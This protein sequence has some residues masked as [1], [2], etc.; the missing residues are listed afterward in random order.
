MTWGA[1]WTWES[2][3]PSRMRAR[4]P[5]RAV[6]TTRLQIACAL[7][8]KPKLACSVCSQRSRAS[9]EAMPHGKYDPQRL[10]LVESLMLTG[11]SKESIVENVMQHYKIRRCVVLRYYERVKRIWAERQELPRDEKLADAWQVAN[12]QFM[13]AKNEGKSNLAHKWFL[14]MLELDGLVKQPAAI[15]VEQGVF[16]NADP[17]GTVLGRDAFKERLNELDARA[18]LL[19]DK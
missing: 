15:N 8:P 1:S 12:R 19:G 13:V 14:T 5:M 17:R 2:I 7:Q 6:T 18:A 16:M 3:S 10:I 4:W 9:G 11:H